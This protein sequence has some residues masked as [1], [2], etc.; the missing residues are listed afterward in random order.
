MIRPEVLLPLWDNLLDPSKLKPSL[1]RVG[2]YVFVHEV[3]TEMLI[4]FPDSLRLDEKPKCYQATHE[5][6]LSVVPLHH[7]RRMQRLSEAWKWWKRAGALTDK[8]E[9]SFE[10]TSSYRHE[11]AHETMAQLLVGNEEVWQSHFMKMVSLL[12]KIDDWWRTNGEAHV[13]PNASAAGNELREH[14]LFNRI[15]LSAQIEAA[16]GDEGKARQL[17]SE[18]E[19]NLAHTLRDGRSHD[20][21]QGQGDHCQ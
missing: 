12:V 9:Q 8:D 19:R 2:L 1:V 11:L 4:A 16:I 7:G 21:V 14:L 15:V 3:L 10:I 20:G 13:G 18:L 17:L 6:R 5:Y